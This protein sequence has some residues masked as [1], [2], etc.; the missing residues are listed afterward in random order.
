M[1]TASGNK[2]GKRIRT[3]HAKIQVMSKRKR[4]PAKS[5]SLN[6]QRDATRKQ[7]RKGQRREN[8]PEQRRGNETTP[9]S[10]DLDVAGLMNRSTRA[11]LELPTRMARCH[12]PFGLWSEQARFMQGII[13]DCQSVAQHLMMNAWKRSP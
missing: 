5:R 11:F 3:P 9:R 1:A 8:G 2:K 10:A 7:V 12:S 13:S 6:T 4:P